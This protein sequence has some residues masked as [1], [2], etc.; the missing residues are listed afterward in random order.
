VNIPR[1]KHGFKQTLDTLIREEA[2]LLAKYIENT[3]KEWIP[4]LAML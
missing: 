1:I 3:E 2:Q 4:R